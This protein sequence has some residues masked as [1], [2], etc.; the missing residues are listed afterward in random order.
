MRSMIS[1]VVLTYNRVHLLR[2]CV[3]NVLTHTSEA[4]HEIIVWNNASTDG[5]REYLDSVSE[6][7]LRVVHHPENIG[8]N[9]YAK[10]FTMATQPYLI[11]LDDDVID[12]PA[13]WDE[14]MLDGFRKLPNVGFLAANLEDDPHD[15]AAHVMHHV[16]PHLY[17]SVTENG[18]RLLKGPTGGGCAITSRE[19]YDKVGGFREKNGE[20]FFLE[21]AAFIADIERL[22]FEAA[23]LEDLRVHHAG[24]AYYSVPPPEKRKYWSRHHRRHARR[25]AA[26]RLLLRV[27]LVRPLN[28]RY[29]WFRTPD[30]SA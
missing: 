14:T 23:F 22:G 30:E 28:A 20:V 17:T 27:P 2:Q 12:A 29:G 18:I 3:E 1:V 5:T 13:R 9:A 8:Q 21:D 7:R 16:R 19:L 25:S 26:K 24:G 11:E 10:A 6:P 4:T 15:E